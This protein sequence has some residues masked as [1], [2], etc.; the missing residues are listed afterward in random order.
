MSETLGLEREKRL[1]TIAEQ[2]EYYKN[3]CVDF[4]NLNNRYVKALAY[5][6]EQRNKLVLEKDIPRFEVTSLIDGLDAELQKIFDA[7]N[8]GEK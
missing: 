8:E 3:M 5:C 2:A 7:K 4:A 1:K 6:R